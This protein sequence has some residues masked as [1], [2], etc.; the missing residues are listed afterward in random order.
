MRF[1]EIRTVVAS[2]GSGKTYALATRYVQL[3]LGSGAD[4]ADVSA[5]APPTLKLRRVNLA[6][7]EPTR[8]NYAIR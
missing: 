2:A 3:L 1:P 6:K 8:K 7:A 5:V 4:Q